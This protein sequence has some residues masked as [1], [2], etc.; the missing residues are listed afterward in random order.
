MPG[1]AAARDVS[2]RAMR[3]CGYGLRSAR[4]QSIPGRVT[5]TVYS[6]S[7]VTL[8]GPSFRGADLPSSLYVVVIWSSPR[9]VMV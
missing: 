7:P 9:L 8:S 2:M 3:A 1:A 4:P 5:S 6:A